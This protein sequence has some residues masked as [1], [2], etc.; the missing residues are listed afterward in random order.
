MQELAGRR[1][2]GQG[3]PQPCQEQP[4]AAPLRGAPPPRAC[5]CPPGSSGPAP[6]RALGWGS[7][8]R[9]AAWPPAGH[10]LTRCPA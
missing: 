10:A 9:P 2:S 1:C 6:R 5:P 3:R 7:S 8:W 4:D